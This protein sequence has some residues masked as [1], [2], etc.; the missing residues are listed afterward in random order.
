MELL[1]LCVTLLMGGFIIIGAL[2]ALKARNSERFTHF[3]I[4]LALGV[5]ARLL[6]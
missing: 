6:F 1:G 2:I 5:M 3:S 4:G